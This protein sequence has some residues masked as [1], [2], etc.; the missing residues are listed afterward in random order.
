MTITPRSSALS[1]QNAPPT[2][3]RDTNAP[4]AADVPPTSRAEGDSQ[5]AQNLASAVHKAKG[6][7]QAPVQVPPSSTL[8]Q[9]RTQLT[10]A[11]KNPEFQHWIM[12]KGIK[13]ESIAIFPDTG[14]IMATINHQRT[15]FTLNDNSGWSTVA[16][17]ILS[18]SKVIESGSGDSIHYHDVFR[19]TMDLRH[20]ASFYGVPALGDATLKEIER[21]RT[22]PPVAPTDAHRSP[23]VRGEKALGEQQQAVAAI[24]QRNSA[25]PVPPGEAQLVQLFTREWQKKLEGGQ[26][27]LVS[28]PLQ[29]TLGQWLDFY[30]ALLETPVVKNW[31]RE[32]N[33][34]PGTLRIV[35]STGAMS[36][37]VDGKTTAF[38]LTDNSGWR[39]IAGPLLEAGKVIAPAPKQ[40]L[41]VSFDQGVAAVSLKVVAKFYGEP[42]PA[43]RAACKPRIEQL[44]RQKTFG[45]R[46]NE[47]Q[48]ADALETLRRNAEKAYAVAPAKLAY[49]RLA[50]GLANAVPNPRAQAKQLAEKI[51]REHLPKE[52]LAKLE[53][54]DADKLYLN[55]FQGG[56]SSSTARSG[57]DH[58]GE[59]PK[60]S[61]TLT[62]AVLSNFTEHDW[63]PGELDNNAGIYIEGPGQS[64]KQG[65]GAH[66]EVA[67]DPSTFMR[68]VWKADFQSEITRKIETF[69]KE[70]GT[71]YRTISKGEFI[72]QARQQL[73]AQE[74]KSAS[75]RASQADEHK[76][77]RSDYQLVMN[78]VSNVPADENTRATLEQLQAQA[79]TED[80]LRAHAFD[81]NGW[82]SNIIRFAD[83][84]DGQYNYENN[85]RDGRQILYVPGATPAFLRFDSLKKMDDWVV[86]QAKDPKKREALASHFSLYNRQDRGV[87][88]KYGVDSALAH[89][90]TGNWDNWEGRTI[91]R[92]DIKIEGDVFTHLSDEAK[93]RMTSD[94]DTVIKSNGEVTRDT[95]L[96]DIG[97]GAGLLIKLAPLGA[98][99]ALAALGS[100][101]TEM[102][103]GSEKSYSGDTLAERKDGAWKTFDGALNTLFSALADGGHAKDPFELPE[104]ELPSSPAAGTNDIPESTP[105]SS[106]GT[107]P[108]NEVPGT[109]PSRQSSTSLIKMSEHALPDGEALI[110]NVTPDALGVYRVQAA[111]GLYRQLVRFTDEMGGNKVFEL[112]GNYKTGDIFASIINPKTGRDVMKVNPGRNGEWGRAP[113][114]G[115]IKWPW[116]RPASPTPSNDLKTPPKVSDGFEIL[117][118][119]KT[120][121]ADKFDE[122]FKSDST[123][124]YEQS[125]NNVE[126]HG[127]IKQKLTVTSTTEEKNFEVYPSERAQPNEHSSTDY[128]P[129]FLKDLNRDRYTVQIKQPDG[130]YTTVELDATGNANGETLS[131][132]LK[133]FEEAIPDPALRSRISEVAHQASVAPTSVE[134]K[135]NQLQDHIGFR[136]K[137]THYTIIYD[138]AVG[139]A[140]VKFEAKMTLVDLDKDAAQIPNVE[141][142]AKR[143]FQIGETNELQDDANPYIIDKNAPFTLSTTVTTDL[144]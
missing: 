7:W 134:L 110:R 12:A 41:S 4:R 1:P 135:M 46:P 99:V 119:P 80:K 93:D 26:P 15:T 32:Q 132:R 105:G 31:M 28:I 125:I 17:P 18:A 143:T 85:R 3:Q 111:D 128:S 69:W 29:T 90:A 102:A 50:T 98:P 118:D 75:E 13:P 123:A 129:N 16:A 112:K 19:E 55:R 6:D 47:R 100:S 101:L 22:F 83:A 14:S 27:G 59:E 64:T 122:I 43:N 52:Q 139:Q 56:V 62:E 54:L 9:W 74:A 38:S 51:L 5:L 10:I 39:Q 116:E 92:R 109:T 24:Y 30:G 44:N 121:G 34:D 95:W 130:S 42:T 37:M 68:G 88:G 141:V 36:A 108:Q 76:F 142:S 140:Q 103:L 131:K 49:T 81:I 25:N 138:P 124:H 8:G 114:D 136:G 106:G 20:I 86:E 94:A 63:L 87:L 104:E 61:Q 137:D 70:H 11:L 97:A 71:D 120:S 40:S 91:D 84:N 79:P 48:S 66:N 45:A 65:Y 115:G 33:I 82:P 77:T 35:P 144:K 113:G 58:P 107:P 53:P 60:R 89:L 126:E 133:Q 57:W 117:G 96:N 72:N 127:V 67:I 2:V 78:A 73:K 21:T 23:S